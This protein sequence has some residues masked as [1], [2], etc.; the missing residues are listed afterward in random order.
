L[1]SGNGDELLEEHDVIPDVGV[2]VGIRRVD[3]AG[4]G[5]KTGRPDSGRAAKGIDFKTGVVGK[6][7]LAGSE[8]GLIGGLDGCVGDEGVA[9]FFRRGDGIGR[10]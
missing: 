3:Q 1:G 4:V 10:G 8:T 2:V 6:N 9:V 5:G 7:K